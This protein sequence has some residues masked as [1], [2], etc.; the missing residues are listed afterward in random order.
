MCGFVRLCTYMKM[1][2]VVRSTVY[3]WGWS[4]SCESSMWR[5]KNQT[6]V[7]QQ[8]LSVLLIVKPSLEPTEC[9]FK[10]LLINLMS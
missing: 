4:C 2:L 8:E 3:P 6:Q 5:A 7:L 10:K 1:F 9:I